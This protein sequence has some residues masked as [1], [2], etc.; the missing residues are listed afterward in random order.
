MPISSATASH[1]CSSSSI[2]SLGSDP[3]AASEKSLSSPLWASIM[4]HHSKCLPWNSPSNILCLVNILWWY[5]N[6][7]LPSESHPLLI[8]FS[9]R[10]SVKTAMVVTGTNVS[11]TQTSMQSRSKAWAVYWPTVKRYIDLQ[12]MSKLS[13]H[14][15]IQPTELTVWSI[16]VVVLYTLWVCG[17]SIS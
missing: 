16:K 7:C 8:H 6:L 12:R 3:G 10:D 1:Q 17:K 15:H 14:C 11:S 13:E 4:W 2:P 5:V 9:S